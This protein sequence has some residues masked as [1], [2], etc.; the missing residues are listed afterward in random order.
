MSDNTPAPNT[1]MLLHKVNRGGVICDVDLACGIGAL[2]IERH[3]GEDQLKRQEPL[4]ATDKGDYWR[5]EGTWN[6]DNQHEGFSPFF[7]S[8]AKFDGRIIDFGV[9]A[10]YHPDPDALVRAKRKGRSR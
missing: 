9:W 5:V 2:V 10:A 1:I 8:I 6:R 4:T 7:M 3:Y